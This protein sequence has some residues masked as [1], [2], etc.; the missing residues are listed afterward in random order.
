MSDGS[1]VGLTR[2][3]HLSFTPKE[4]TGRIGSLL[5]SPPDSTEPQGDCGEFEILPAQRKDPIR[6][7]MAAVVLAFRPLT[8]PESSRSINPFW[9]SVARRLEDE[10]ETDF[11]TFFAPIT[12]N[13]N[14]ELQQVRNMAREYCN[15]THADY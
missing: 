6:S 7:L 11:A 3:S 10:E 5:Q 1:T 8:E 13:W 2:A 15:Q 4:F 9:M 14:R 12:F